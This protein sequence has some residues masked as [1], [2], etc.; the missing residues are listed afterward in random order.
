MLVGFLYKTVAD[1]LLKPFSLAR[2]LKACNKAHELYNY[3]NSTD[4]A[5]DIYV[6]SGYEQFRVRFEDILYL[7]ATGNYV[8]FVLSEKKILSRNTF[9]EVMDLL[10]EDRFVRVHRSYIASISKIEKIERDQ[11][12][13]KK[14]EIPVS[15]TYRQNL[16]AMLG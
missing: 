9:A 10:P 3:R 12:T 11:I 16:K 5:D 7:E 4:A 1:Y 13:I 8:T 2:F 14:E 15:D 6:K